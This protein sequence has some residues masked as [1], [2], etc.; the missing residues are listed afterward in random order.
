MATA[1]HIPIEELSAETRAFI[2]RA[3]TASD[4]VV[5]SAGERFRISRIPSRT[6]SEVLSDPTITWSN[7]IPDKE[8]GKD[9]EEIIALR[10]QE[11]SDPWTE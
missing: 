4:I 1:V 6:L 7:A 2:E 5:D 9:L 8:W 3:E 10:K 11:I